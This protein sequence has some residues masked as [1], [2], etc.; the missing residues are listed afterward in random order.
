MIRL[1]RPHWLKEPDTRGQQFAS[2][3]QRVPGFGS[4]LGLQR[5]VKRQ[6]AVLSYSDNVTRPLPRFACGHG[7]VF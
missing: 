7:L 2:V 6:F 5:R 3:T 1:H 4:R